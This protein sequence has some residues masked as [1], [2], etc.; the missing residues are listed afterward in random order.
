MSMLKLWINNMKYKDG[1]FKF[2][3]NNKW[4][5][6]YY[7]ES[8]NLFLEH[9]NGGCMHIATLKDFIG[10]I[11]SNDYGYELVSILKNLKK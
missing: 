7:E 3:I 4:V 11:S 8:H 10:W 1:H 2:L 5:P 6:K 9:P